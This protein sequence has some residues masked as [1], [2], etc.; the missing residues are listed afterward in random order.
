MTTIKT[1]VEARA[2]ILEAISVAGREA[3]LEAVIEFNNTADNDIDAEGNV[4]VSNPQV[5]H[6]L[7][8][9]HLIEFAEFLN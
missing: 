6:W 4:W 5:G 2:H 7:N 9:D 1:A 8:D 3:V